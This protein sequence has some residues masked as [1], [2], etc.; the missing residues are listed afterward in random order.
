MCVLLAGCYMPAPKSHARLQVE[1]DG[2]FAFNGRP[3]ADAE[4]AAALAA[5]RGPAAG[6]LVVTIVPASGSPVARVKA[7]VA[8]VEQAHARVAFAGPA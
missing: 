1:P 6:D 2:G 5:A 8:A 3:L 4:L 7:A